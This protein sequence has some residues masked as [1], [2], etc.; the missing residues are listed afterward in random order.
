MLRRQLDELT[1]HIIETHQQSSSTAMNAAVTG[2]TEAVR[3]MGQSASKPRPEDMIVGK[4]EPYA[5]GQDFGDWDFTFN[6]YAGT[7]DPAY[8][9]LL[10]TARQ[11]PTVVMATP[12][13]EQWSAT[14]LYLLTMLIQK[15]ARKVVRKAGNNGFEAYRQLC[16]MYGTSDQEGSTGLSVQIMTYK[17][18]SKIEDV[19]DRLNEFLALVR[20]HDEANGTDPVP[21][22]VKKACIIS[23]TPEPLKTHLQLNVAKLGNF[24]AS[25]VATEDYLRS[26]RIFKTTSAGNT[27]DEDAMEVIVI[28]RKGKGKEKSG[29][30]KKGG[31][32]GKETHSGKGY[33]E[34]TTEHSRFEG[35]CRNCGKY[36]HKA[37]ECWYKQPPKPQGKSKGTGKSI[38][39]VTEIGES[40]SSKQ[41][42]ETWTL[43]TS[44]PQP[45]LSQVNTI[46][47]ADEGTL[48]IFAG[49]QQE[50]SVHGELGRSVFQSN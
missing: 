4:S 43:H 7:F 18:G 38:S 41:V 25:R 8:P 46:G 19:E 49:R 24:N 42:E 3:T 13:H 20:R 10:K 30:G 29:K 50:T 33:G 40:D 1:A 45:S 22:Q 12:P 31:K 47:C 48:D 26:R 23:N 21:D 37:A 36:G 14:L 17:S 5:P 15:G 32:K 28:S 34:T 6:G 39:K 44:T 35:E 27:H 9:A 2:L 11:S 16:L